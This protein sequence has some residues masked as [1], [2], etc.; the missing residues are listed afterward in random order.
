MDTRPRQKR[1]YLCLT[2]TLAVLLLLT[3]SLAQIGMGRAHAAPANPIA[4][5]ITSP[6]SGATLFVSGTA[7]LP[8][9]GVIVSATSSAGTITAVTLTMNGISLGNGS[10]LS[11]TSHSYLIPWYPSTAGFIT[12][13]ATAY[14]SSGASATSAPVQVTVEQ[15]G[16]A[17]NYVM[18]SQSPGSF[19]SMIIIKS[20]EY[21]S[22]WT[23][24]FTFP[25][26]QQ[27]TQGWNGIYSQNGN[28][29]TVTNTSYDASFAPGGT[30][31][32]GFNATWSGSNPA[33]TRFVLNGILCTASMTT[34]CALGTMLPLPA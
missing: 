24:S 18:N 31:T 19:S 13:I 1:W 27:I 21:T 32:T 10:L 20:G 3:L 4:V 33:P 25:A 23:L 12:F 29:V 15:P 9:S 34:L 16:F 17:V 8:G 6:A 7:P 5:S 14:D 11:G 28:Q 30:V 2:P 22:G 26:N